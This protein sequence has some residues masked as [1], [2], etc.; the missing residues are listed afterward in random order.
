VLAGA[1]TVLGAAQV[2]PEEA[3]VTVVEWVEAAELEPETGATVPEA[4]LVEAL[5]D[6]LEPETGATV[7]EALVE[8]LV[9]ELAG[10]TVLDAALVEALVAELAGATVLDA[11]LVEALVDEL[12]GATVPDAVLLEALVDELD[13]ET[14]ATVP[15]ALEDLAVPVVDARVEAGVVAGAQAPEAPPI[16][17]E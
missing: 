5:V 6:E 1:V 3:A 13:P 4:A 15:E 9:A 17:L 16:K 10:A 8:A 11:A 7:P 14:G 2:A 12:A